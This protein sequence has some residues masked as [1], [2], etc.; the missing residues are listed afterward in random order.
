M[1]T[2][3]IRRELLGMRPLPNVP[4]VDWDAVSRGELGPKTHE[5]YM[6][7]CT[8]TL[9]AGA[10]GPVLMVGGVPYGPD[11]ILPWGMTGREFVAPEADKG[12]AL[13]RTF[14]GEG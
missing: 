13:A 2:V 8:G 6:V 14:I 5:T 12:V 7:A 10:E 11:D 3:T 9:V 4:P 1:T